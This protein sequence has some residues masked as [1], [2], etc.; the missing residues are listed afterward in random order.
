M[1]TLDEIREKKRGIPDDIVSYGDLADILSTRHGITFS[2]SELVYVDDFEERFLTSIQ[3]YRI[4]VGSTLQLGT[5]YFEEAVK[6]THFREN[7]I[8]VNARFLTAHV[9]SPSRDVR[10]ARMFTEAVLRKFC[11]EETDQANDAAASIVDI[12]KSFVDV[13]SIGVPV[14]FLDDGIFTGR[15]VAGVVDMLRKQGTSVATVYSVIARSHA[16]RALETQLGDNTR[17]AVLGTLYRTGWDHTRDLIG[18][19]GLRLDSGGYVPYWNIPRL[20]SLSCFQRDGLVSICKKFFAEIADFLFRSYRI[21]FRSEG[22]SLVPER[23]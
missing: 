8:L 14:G 21:R 23:E 2:K 13:R 20:I 6:R 18:I 3:A 12:N 9:L 19:H 1:M 15:T 10:V 11:G 4:G 5:A 17:F 22:I 16:I 7:L